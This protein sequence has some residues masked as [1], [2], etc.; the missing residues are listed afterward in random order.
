MIVV[1]VPISLGKREE[2]LVWCIKVH[3][4]DSICIEKASDTLLTLSTEQMV[5]IRRE[6]EIATVQ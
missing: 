5:Q 3:Q 1:S 4:Y 2:R 6:M